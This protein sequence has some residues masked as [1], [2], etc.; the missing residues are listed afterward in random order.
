MSALPLPV[1]HHAC[2]KRLRVAAR[3]RAMPCSL[4]V[5]RSRHRRWRTPPSCRLKPKM[6]GPSKIEKSS[7]NFRT[8]LAW[9]GLTETCRVQNPDI[10]RAGRLGYAH[11]R[12]LFEC[13]CMRVHACTQSVIC[14]DWHTII[15]VNDHACAAGDGHASVMRHTPN[16]RTK[17]LDFIGFDS[18][19]VWC[20]GAGILKPAGNSPEVLSQGILAGVILVGRLAVHMRACARRVVVSTATTSTTTT[21]TNNNNHDNNND[22][23]ND[24]NT[25]L[26]AKVRPSGARAAC[27]PEGRDVM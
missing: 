3:R 27:P 6:E 15:R 14:T 26:R 10:P 9:K 24:N 22:N 23:N 13:A 12:V 17:I 18:I 4:R 25:P 20:L 8:C 2:D 5:A 21:T 16:L 7:S 19:I 1:P 11:A